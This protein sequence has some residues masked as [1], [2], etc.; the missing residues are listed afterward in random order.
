MAKAWLCSVVLITH[1]F[2]EVMEHA[3]DVTVLR[4]GRQTA[5]AM[6]GNAASVL[7]GDFLYSRAFQM[8]VGTHRMRVLEVLADLLRNASLCA[9]GQ[10]SPNPVLST[11][12]YFRP[13]YE[14]FLATPEPPSETA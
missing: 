5:N 4:R 3:D 2:R 6:F 14:A 12:R 11:L 1:K 7:V 13:E 9:L 10:T 8:M